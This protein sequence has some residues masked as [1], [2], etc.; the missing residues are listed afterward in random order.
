[1][2]SDI[3]VRHAP[4]LVKYLLD[5]N[6]V[7][8]PARPSPSATVLEKLRAHSGD[9]ALPSIGWHELTYGASRLPDGRRRRYLMRYLTGVVRPS[10]PVV[11]YDRAAAEWHGRVRAELEG[12]GRP[13][14]FADGQIAAIAATRDLRVVTRNTSDFAPF[15]D[16]SVQNGY[17]P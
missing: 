15:T 6:V 12:R 2:F 10:M 11:P 17:D 14:S 8:E 5:T 13:T 1:V 16:V 3:P 4:L 9:L 7:S